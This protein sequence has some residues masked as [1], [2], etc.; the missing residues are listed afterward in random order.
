[1]EIRAEEDFGFCLVGDEVVD[2]FIE[3]TWKVW[4]TRGRVEDCG[5]SCCVGY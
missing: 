3:G 5:D 2:C 1:V 4:D